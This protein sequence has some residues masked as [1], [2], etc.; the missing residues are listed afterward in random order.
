[1]FRNYKRVAPAEFAEAHKFIAV[2]DNAETLQPAVP[3][4][5]CDEHDN[6]RADLYCV[7]CNSAV[8]MY[9]FTFSHSAHKCSDIGA[10][11]DR[12]RRQ[13][14]S[15]QN[16]LAVG[17]EK[18]KIALLSLRIKKCDFG[19][20]VAK[21]KDEIAAKA[22]Q[23]KDMID[24]HQ[25][26][27][28][29]ELSSVEQRKMKAIDGLR[30]EAER[31]LSSLE[32][33]RKCVDDVRQKGTT[34]IIRRLASSLHSRADELLM[35]DVNERSLADVGHTNVTFTSSDFVFDD[36]NKTLGHLRVYE[37][38]RGELNAFC[39]CSLSYVKVK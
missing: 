5:F 27:L 8:C 15:D 24:D 9:C 16:N 33:H 1:M 21:A 14:A 3:P 10:A 4:T 31:Q 30:E 39:L 11:D 18:R 19:K 29:N 20:Q 38:E 37:G 13:M 28:V 34:S 6:Q 22:E 32:G 26:M 35:S 36:V 7:D 12:F 25:Q 2:G 17:V 23:L